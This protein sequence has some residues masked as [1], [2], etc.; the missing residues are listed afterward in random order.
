MKSESKIKTYHIIILSLFLS[1]LLILNSDNVN[2]QRAQKKINEDKNKIFDKIISKRNLQEPEESEEQTGTDKVCARGSKELIKYYQTGDMSLIGLKEDEGIQYDKNSKY[3]EA[4]KLILKNILEEDDEDEENGGNEAGG[5]GRRR[6]GMSF[7]GETKDAV[8]DY[9][10]HLLPIIIFFALGLL[11]IPAWPICCFCCCCNCCCCCC[12]KKRGC[13]I[14]CFIFTY[15]FYALVIAICIYGL[16]TT[17]KIFVGIAD[18]ECSML[19][20]FDEVLDG[21]TKDAPKWAG[22]AGIQNML[23]NMESTLNSIHDSSLNQLDTEINNLNLPSGDKE[24]FLDELE[25][26]YKKFFQDSACT[27]YENLYEAGG[28]KYVLDIIKTFGKFTKST[29]EGEPENSLM[30]MWAREFKAVSD[31]SDTE[32][33]NAKEHFHEICDS[34][35]GKVIDILHKGQT[36]LGEFKDKF[37]DTRKSFPDKIVSNSEDIDKYGKLGSKAIFGVLGLINIAIAVLMLFIFLCSGKMCKNCCCCRCLCKFFTHLLWNILY[38]LMIFTFF[39]GF[40]FSF[41]GQLGS[42]TMNILSYISSED[43]LGENGDNFLSGKIGKYKKYINTCINGE[44]DIQTLVNIDGDVL[45]AF[46]QLYSAEDL[47]DDYMS[48]FNNI[49]KIAYTYAHD[50][51]ED[52]HKFDLAKDDFGYILNEIT[53]GNP[54]SKLFYQESLNSINTDSENTGYKGWS[55]TCELNTCDPG[56]ECYKLNSDSCDIG[57]KVVGTKALEN[58][59]IIKALNTQ[60]NNEYSDVDGYKNI[61]ENLGVSYT[62]FIRAY[63]NVLSTARTIIHSITVLISEYTGENGGFFSIV[64]C[65]FIGKHLKVLL[66]NLKSSLG[67]SV[68]TVGICLSVVGCSLILSISSTILLIVIINKSIEE[69]KKEGQS[70]IPEYPADSAGRTIAYKNI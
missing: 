35:F 69:D 66:D 14:P 31:G 43:N 6:L 27:Q 57:I 39:I 70:A 48:Q 61:I 24:I 37:D 64:N 60:I 49:P 63:T 1:S 67:G 21:E 19:K 18:T 7:E 55:S 47:I 29:K 22:I 28:G 8:V 62:N 41:V 10:M 17:N 16:S 38:L 4:L 9:G 23:S 40:I 11:A 34:S 65:K 54:P 32:L 59:K 15:V 58:A 53:S 3:M 50:K 36:K 56:K 42:D 20:F 45:E 26:S 46:D 2:K 25:N 51:I 68:K 44:G 52:M 12:C 5:N 13:K 30:D 33:Q